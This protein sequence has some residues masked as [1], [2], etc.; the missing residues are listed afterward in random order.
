M[1]KDMK[2]F[3][4]ALTP[5]SRLRYLLW[6]VSKSNQTIVVNLQRGGRL[7]IRPQPTTDTITGYEIFSAEAYEKPQQVPTFSPKFIVDIG[8]NVGHSLVYW[9]NLYPESKLI[10]FEPHPEHLLMVYKNLQH[11]SLL[12][13][14]HVVGSAASNK[15]AKSFL[16]NNENES[17]VVDDYQAGVFQIKVRDLFEEIENET[18]DLLKMDIEGGEYPILADPRFE[19]LDARMIV[20]EWHNTPEVPNGL[21]WCKNRLVSLGYQVTAGKLTY[22]T[23]GILWAWKDDINNN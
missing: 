15:N 18:V 4:D 3:R 2:W 23:A 20:L 21:E 10:A 14:V 13:R 6:R 16:T 7:E 19:K 11:N 17:I 1:S 22:P 9:A 12:N 8:A 5:A